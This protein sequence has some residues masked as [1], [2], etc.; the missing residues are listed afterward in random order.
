M[1]SR[2][3]ALFAAALCCAAAVAGPASADPQPVP[4]PVALPT[5][6]AAS[7]VSPYVKAALDLATGLL[8]QRLASDP[9]R[10]EGDVTY[11][12]RFDL[13]VR[14]GGNAYRDVRL[15]PGTRIDPRGATIR[16]GD[17]VSVAG[18]GRPDGT[19]EADAITILR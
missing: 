8:R 19:L 3:V 6:P 11:F 15:H 17:R 13:Q 7:A 12:K 1:R 14:M 4:T 16:A 10:A 5:M 18:T 2:F 9:N